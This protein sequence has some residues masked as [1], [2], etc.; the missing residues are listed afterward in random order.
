MMRWRSLLP[1]ALA[2]AACFTSAP[3]RA[4]AFDLKPIV[5]QLA[6]S[7]SASSRSIIVTNSHDEP[8]AIEVKAFKRAQSPD[9]SE[10]RTPEDEDL[11]ISPPQM[12]VPAKTSQN[13]KVQWIGDPAP[14]RELAFRLIAEQLPIK[15]ATSTPKDGVEATVT[16]QYKYEAALYI[17]P[18][19]SAPA[20]SVVGAD[21][22]RS[23][24]GAKSLK[25]TLTSSG[26]RRAILERPE[27]TLTP[28]AGGA[29][30]TLTGD[31]LKGVAGENILAGAERQFLLPWPEGLAE[32]PVEA[33]LKTGFLVFN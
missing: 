27:L 18:P 30:V 22:V 33:R 32:G 17:T 3:D 6:P 12:V 29:A 15:L 1:A 28:G 10:Q 4:W 19:K 9:G 24:E 5:I 20:I 21:L 31:Q 8:I 16:M 23:P 7:G 25:L 26:T 11:I 2:V 14:E 13:F